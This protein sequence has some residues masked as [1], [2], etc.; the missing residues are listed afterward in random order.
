LSQE[1]ALIDEQ[2]ARFCAHRKNVARYQLLLETAITSAERL[3]IEQLLARE[4]AAL[5]SLV[6]S[7][8]DCVDG[9]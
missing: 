1:P 8:R 6:I 3:S 7:T 4:L 5:E 9:S 2:D